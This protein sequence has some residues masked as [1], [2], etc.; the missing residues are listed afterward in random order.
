M[1]DPA[2]RIST[3]STQPPDESA[4]RVDR[5]DTQTEPLV[6]DARRLAV[7]LGSGVRTVRTWDASGKL[8]KPIRIG[9]RVVWRVVEIREWLAAG[10]PDRATWEARKTAF[11]K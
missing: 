8:P 9:G 2:L 3:V 11:K 5:V 6:A 10:A 1:A 7:L 4:A